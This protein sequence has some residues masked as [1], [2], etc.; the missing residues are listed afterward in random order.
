MATPKHSNPN[1]GRAAVSNAAGRFEATQ[2]AAFDDGWPAPEEDDPPP[3]RTTV[4]PDRSKSIIARNQSP[5]IGFD[6]SINPYRGCEHGCIYCFA[7]PTHAW[8]GLSPGLDFEAKLFAKH[9]AAALLRETLARPKYQP[10]VIAIGTNTDPYQPIERRLKIMRSILEVLAEA[11]HPVA[12]TT[13]SDAVLRDLDILVDLARDNL[14]HVTL[15]VTTLDRKLARDLEP[16]ATTPMRRIDAIRKLAAAKV[17]V[18]VNVAPVIP[19]LTDHEIDAILAESAAAGA[20][21]ARY[22]ALRLPLEV[23]DLFEEWLTVNRPDRKARVLSLMRSMR[24]GKLNEAA[25]GKRMKG[26]GPYAELIAQRFRLAAA[27]NGLDR[28]EEESWLRTDAFRAPERNPA[29][30]TLGL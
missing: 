27:R 1:R 17:P 21:S 22:I 2:A 25:F 28:R 12:I 26:E 10:A 29:Q 16:R 7:R 30:M 6:R 11:R 9:D 13:K 20:E 8:L 23:K 4:T 24:G 14:A 19:G 15:S 3:L 5:D 18:A